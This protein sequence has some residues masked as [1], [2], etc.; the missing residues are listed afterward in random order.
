M[1]DRAEGGTS[2]AAGPHEGGPGEARGVQVPVDDTVGNWRC[3]VCGL[4]YEDVDR[5]RSEGGE[6]YVLSSL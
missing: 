6:R 5:K 4:E 1:E 3:E 2:E